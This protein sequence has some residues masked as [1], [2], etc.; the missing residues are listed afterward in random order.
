MQ[1]ETNLLPAHG[2][3]AVEIL[4]NDHKVIK[5][6][7]TELTEATANQRKHV[8]DQLKGALTIHNAT[9]ENLVYP[10]LNRVAGSKREAQHLYHET[11]EADTLLFE[12]DS[13]LKEHDASDFKTSAREFADAVRHHIEEEEQKALP[14]LRENADESQS[15]LLA[16]SVKEFRKSIHFELPE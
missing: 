7:L 3:D 5:R 15:E 2:K 14:R 6:L 12:L 13:M 1:I 16:E 10:A 11:S 9:E 8:L 4:L